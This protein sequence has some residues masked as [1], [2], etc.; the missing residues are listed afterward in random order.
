MPPAGQ[1][2][3]TALEQHQAWLHIEAVWRAA[4]TATTFTKAGKET[5]LSDLATLDADGAIL[6]QAGLVDEA[7]VLLLAKGRDDLVSTL[8][9]RLASDETQK[10]FYIPMP[11]GMAE[12]QSLKR[13]RERLPWLERLAASGQYHDAVM[14][15][16]LPAMEQEATSLFADGRLDQVS[17]ADRPDAL[18]VKESVLKTVAILRQARGATDTGQGGK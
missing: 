13:M 8:R 2:T 9:L 18:R 5:L 1:P 15:L 14:A 16:V 3:V 4:R 12:R 17:E 10:T 7:E 6:K 11:P